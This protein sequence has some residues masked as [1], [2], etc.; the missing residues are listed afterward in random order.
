MSY[1]RHQEPSTKILEPKLLVLSLVYIVNDKL[2]GENVEIPIS[3][4]LKTLSMF[5]KV[6]GL[7][8]S[9]QRR[10]MGHFGLDPLKT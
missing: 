1:A 7:K 5:F 3:N 2:F 8:E 10:D 4:N 6:L 9:K